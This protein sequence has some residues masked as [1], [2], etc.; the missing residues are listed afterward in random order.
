[1]I[2][3]L[4]ENAALY[5]KVSDRISKGLEYLKNTDL[6]KLENGKYEIDGSDVYASVMSYQTKKFEDGKYE[7]HNKYI[8]IQ[9]IVSGTEKLY[10]AP[11]KDA[12]VTTA[13][14]EEKDIYFLQANGDHVTAVAGSFI[15]FYPTEAHMPC[16]AV[17][18]QSQVKK[19]VVKVRV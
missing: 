16:I 3:D 10:Y 5:K 7:A 11:L 6:E 15:I 9:Y 1:M 14:N 12:K 13:Y 17:G 4:I 8:D 19:V 18:D 2:T